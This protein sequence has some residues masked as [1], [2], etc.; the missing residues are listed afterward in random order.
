MHWAHVT[1]N[2]CLWGESLERL[3]ERVGEKGGGQ[4]DKRMRLGFGV[5]GFVCRAAW[6][7]ALFELLFLSLFHSLELVEGRNLV[8]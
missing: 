2:H 6:K 3:F 8:L 4:K 1:I 5:W 7:G